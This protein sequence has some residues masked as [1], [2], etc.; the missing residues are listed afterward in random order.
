MRDR[1][2]RD[3]ISTMGSKTLKTTSPRNLLEWRRWLAAHHDS[4]S[5]VWLVFHK[6][7]TGRTSIAY[8]DALDEALCFGWID[9]L[10]RRID[11]ECYARKFTPRKPDSKWSAINRERYA[12]LA[13]SG[14]LKPAGLERP[15]T[16]RSYAPKPTIPKMPRY[17]AEAL[18]ERPRA[19]GHFER[20]PPSHRRYIIGWIDS[21]K[22]RETK[23]RRLAEALR[24]LSAGKRL[25][26][27]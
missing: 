23:L 18:R 4:E 24:V 11:D 15:P 14:R 16:E 3:T 6:R 22:K 8:L 17:I 25:G 2:T 13:D 7:H 19:L 21:A 26:L 10:I 5:E 1:I 12:K 9:S 20:L 27:K